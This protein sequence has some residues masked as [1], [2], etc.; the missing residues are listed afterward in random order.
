MSITI[1]TNNLQEILLTIRFK[2]IGKSNQNSNF[3]GI[4]QKKKVRK[5]ILGPWNLSAPFENKRPP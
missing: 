1:S 4:W 5:I 2:R 3:K